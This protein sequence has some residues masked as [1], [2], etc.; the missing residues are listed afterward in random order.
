MESNMTREKE[1]ASPDQESKFIC[2]TVASPP[3]KSQIMKYK[4]AT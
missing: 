2:I 4:T 3:N 1:M